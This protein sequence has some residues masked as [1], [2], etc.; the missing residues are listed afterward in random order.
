MFYVG[1]N[2]IKL[3]KRRATWESP[4][5][6]ILNTL[7]NNSCIDKDVSGEIRNYIELNDNIKTCQNL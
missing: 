5:T 4:K 3:K 7:P 1:Y 2:S 6:W